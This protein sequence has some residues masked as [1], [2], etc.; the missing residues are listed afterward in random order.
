M[1]SR[2]AI[3]KKT[4]TAKN[5]APYTY[6]PMGEVI[7]DQASEVSGGTA[8]ANGQLHHVFDPVGNLNYRANNTLIVNFAVI[9]VHPVR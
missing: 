7:A 2:R 6:D 1:Q 9:P 8:R 4:R 3:S 5:T